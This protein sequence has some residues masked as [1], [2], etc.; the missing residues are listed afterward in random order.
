MYQAWIAKRF[1]S[2]KQGRMGLLTWLGVIGVAIGVASLFLAMAV[3]SGYVTT[4]K[5]NII[6][7]TGHIMLINRGQNSFEQ[8]KS[9]I[10]DSGGAIQSMTPFVMLEGVAAFKGKISGIMI[11]GVENKSYQSVFNIHR[12]TVDG[13][14]DL[15]KTSAVVIGTGLRDNLNLK[16][17]DDLKVVIPVN[18]G[19]E[20]DSF[21]PKLLK[22]KVQA[23]VDLG[24]YEYN[25]RYLMVNMDS[26]NQFRASED[27][28][29]GYRILLTDDDK[30]ELVSQN[31][32]Q[33]KPQSYWTKSWK[34]YNANLF[35][36]AEY[37]KYIIF[38]VLLIIIIAASVNVSII[39][40]VSV[41]KRYMELSMLKV[42]G[43]TKASIVFMFTCQGLLIGFF[44]ALLGLFLGW[45]LSFTLIWIQKTWNVLPAEVYQIS[46]L[47][48]DIR[49]VDMALIVLSTLI[50]CGLASFIPA[51]R[52]ARLNSITGL[53]AE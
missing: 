38:F 9:D 30:A 13:E 12:R 19:I 5:T 11:E 17:G 32:K 24:R 47:S 35:H 16:V 45:L 36:A 6:D 27:K 46:Y 50:I 22:L 20:Q 23:V 48:L 29:S 25:Q 28:V 7:M 52:G 53:R 18:N 2:P 1:L 44:G 39:L 42:M 15:S 40:F 41:I 21:V 3:V 49:M 37:E 4:L 34:E 26:L 33:L 51:W 10:E 8:I 31:L 43:M 14:I